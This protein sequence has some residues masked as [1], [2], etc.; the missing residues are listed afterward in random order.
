LEH[1]GFV[2][3][4]LKR[5]F[6]DWLSIY[7][8]VSSSLAG[9]LSD[10]LIIFTDGSIGSNSDRSANLLANLKYKMFFIK[11]ILSYTILLQQ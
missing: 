8:V 3:R 10:F 9:L 6:G 7:L 1:A 4:L 2:I 5:F 11:T